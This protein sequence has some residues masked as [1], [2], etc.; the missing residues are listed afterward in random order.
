[1]SRNH[2]LDG[3]RGL[4]A[5]TVALAHCNLAV[6]GPV[7]WQATIR[8]FGSLPAREIAS[9]LL[10][11]VFPGHAAVTLFFVLSGHVLW[12]S[13]LRRQPNS[14]FDLP[15][16]LVGRAYRLLPVAAASMIPLAFLTDASARELV[17][18]MLLLSH[19]INGVLWS[20]QVEAICSLAIALAWLTTRGSPLRVAILLAAVLALSPLFR[21]SNFFLYFPAFLLGA[22]IDSVPKAVWS[23][24]T[25]LGAGLAALVLSH[26]LI[27]HAVSRHA[28]M[29]G[30]MVVVG[31][32]GATPRPALL[33]GPVQFLGAVSYPFYL[34]H[35]AAL[36]LGK[37][38]GIGDS[39]ADPFATMALLALFSVP[40]ALAI[41]WLLHV[42]VEEPV[43]RARPRL[44]LSGLRLRFAAGRNSLPEPS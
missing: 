24:G 14:L 35:P 17:A 15:D 27:P 37:V 26:L 44:M 28:E 16:Y 13:F 18:N 36:L 40:I 38:V 10:Y 39:T 19:S 30:A 1:M 25:V 22:L 5:L 31:C 4:A 11:V 3:L 8:D 20:L 9:S 7:P 34:A 32:I 33:T 43:M 29:L 6:M 12:R 41:A 23:R 2:S 42:A 21:G